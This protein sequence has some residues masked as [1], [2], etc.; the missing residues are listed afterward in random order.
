MK[1]T[2][3][4]SVYVPA[5][6]YRLQFNHSFTFQQAEQLLDYLDDLGITDCYASPLLMARPGSLHGYDVTDHN[7]FNPEIG[8]S[9]DFFSLAE[10]LRHHSMGMILDVVPNHMCI[11]DSTNVWWWDV[12]ENGPSSPYACF[13]DIDWHPPKSELA[14]KV[15]LP[16]LGDQY[17]RVLENREITIVYRD[18]AFYMAF[19]STFLPVAPRTWNI[20][21]ERVL[22]I[23]KEELDETQPHVLE[24][25]SI[26][27][28][29]AHLPLRTETED[30]K[31]RERLR[32]KEIIK[33][34]LGEL[35]K[36]SHAVST[37]LDLSVNQINGRQ[38]D[39]RSFDSLER[40]LADQAYRVSS[41]RVASDEINY[42]RF[43]DINDLAAIRV[44]DLSVFTA[45]HALIFDLIRQG[46]V[47]GLRIDHPDGLFDP[48]QYFLDLQQGCLSAYQES[49]TSPSVAPLH[50]LQ[51]HQVGSR[52][53]YIVAEKILVRDEELNPSW[54]IE[55]T[56]GYGFLNFL[57][58]VFVD[59]SKKRVFNKLY[60]RFA[61]WSQCFDDLVYESKRLI[62]KVSMSSELRV[63]SRQLDRISEQHR[64]SRDFTLVNLRDALAEVITCFPVYRTYIR[65]SHAE[66]DAEDRRHILNAIHCA[67]RR[68]PAMSE[69]VFDF[70]RD[71]LFLEDVD[72]IDEAQRAERRHFVMRLQQFTGPVMAKG[73][74]DTA[75]YR[76]YPLASLNEVGGDPEQF[77]TS[78][79]F[80][81][82]KNLI[83]QTDW[84]QAML[85]T[86]THDTKRGEDVR[87]RINVLS[88]IP[89]E[90]FHTIRHWQ[91]LN[92]ARKVTVAGLEVPTANE[93]YLLYQTLVGVWPFK[94]MDSEE[95][96]RFVARIQA[97]MEKAIKEAKLHTS[98]I[99]PNIAYEKAVRDFVDG[100]LALSPENQFLQEFLP[101]QEKIARAG[102]YNSLAQVL[103][104][105]ASPGVPDFYQG[106]ELW[107]L[108]LVDPDNR[109]P[110]D[111]D[112]RRSLLRR[113]L[114]ARKEPTIL[115]GELMN[116]PTDGAIKLYLTSRALR[117]RKDRRE[118]FA[119]GSYVALRSMGEQK[120][121]VVAFARKLGTQRVIALAGRFFMTLGADKRPP[122]GKE[123]WGESVVM[124]R[125][126]MS[127]DGYQDVL[128]NREVCPEKREGKWVLPLASVFSHLPLALLTNS[129]S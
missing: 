26:L 88:E 113:I 76:Y 110:V 83:R 27:T 57:N 48:E 119:R 38:G 64:W 10:G 125:S 25:E 124:L 72:G 18:G 8:S 100:I 90:W 65:S 89:I 74:E 67:K 15:L 52:R 101:F 60:N 84:P 73:L 14:D 68:N 6:T 51:G 33:R 44:E 1:R 91:E 102:I 16:V 80:F 114:Q 123:V 127:R 58:G 54:S 94:A 111:Y 37:A 93:E 117:F 105:I 104:K 29:L 108:T 61:G 5:S 66:P 13:F 98:W 46:I 28:S 118:L 49:H 71:L 34:R 63:L 129:K 81:H 128:T 107:N 31:V 55:G 92:R 3:I 11:S 112:T 59:S 122:T 96:L 109:Q 121:H 106:S 12:L 36:N 7:R 41:W 22:A 99:S 42:R 17:G 126:G 35:V 23:L 82:G 115:V 116:D 4:E 120:R 78:A 97:Y 56:T 19:Y 47:S 2:R 32:E 30:E 79:E 70:I 43:F 95:H 24:L 50:V 53:F 86:S 77:G 9:A 21:L 103:L 45:V 75:F 39:P 40:L 20:I 62:L 85:A 69:S 87:A